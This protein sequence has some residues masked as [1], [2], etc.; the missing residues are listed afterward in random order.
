[1]TSYYYQTLNPT[2]FDIIGNNS[3]ML[4]AINYFVFLSHNVFLKSFE[5]FIFIYRWIMPETCGIAP[6]PCYPGPTS[7]GWST[8]TWR[9]RWATLAAVEQ[10]LN[11]GWSGSLR[12]S[13]GSPTSTSNSGKM[14]NFCYSLSHIV[15][16]RNIIFSTTESLTEPK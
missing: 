6:L 16:Y 8:H 14:L 9:R 11:G 1:M 10:S 2:R 3:G 12:T 5:S 13:T 7:C 15:R 4:V